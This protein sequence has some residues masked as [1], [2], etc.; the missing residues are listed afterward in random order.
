MET[1]ESPALY[2][3]A[4]RSFTGFFNKLRSVM[5]RSDYAPEAT[6][7]SHSSDS[8]IWACFLRSGRGDDTAEPP[9]WR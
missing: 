6:Q 8:P 9:R 7:R 1:D 5:R 2:L 3:K 4:E